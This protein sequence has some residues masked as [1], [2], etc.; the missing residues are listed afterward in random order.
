MSGKIS[1]KCAC[2]VTNTIP[3]IDK[4]EERKDIGTQGTEEAVNEKKGGD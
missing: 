1:L 4:R 3:G 2:G